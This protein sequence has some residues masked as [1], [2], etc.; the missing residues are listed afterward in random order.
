M[1]RRA[2]LVVLSRRGRSSIAAADWDELERRATVRVVQRNAAPSHD[3]AVELLSGADLLGSTNPCLPRFDAALLDALPDLRAIV[4]YATG[5]DH[6]D[7]PLLARRNVGLSVLPDYATVAVAEH[8]LALLLALATRL[9]LAH[10]RCRGAAA[11]GASL[12][13]IELSDRTIGVIGHGRIGSRVARMCAAL[14]STIV[15]CDVEPEAVAAATAT[16]FA[17]ADLAR[18]LERS[19]AVVV[20]AS[21]EHG[22]PPII[23]KRELDVLRPGSL[24]VNVSRSALVDTDAT[25]AAIRAGRV[26]GYAVDDIVVDPHSD[27][28]L[29][30]EGR[31]LQT[32]HSAWWRDEVLQRGARMWSENLLAAVNGDLR[33]DVTRTGAVGGPPVRP[34]SCP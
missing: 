12:R 27:G 34:R 30:E 16:G 2:T 22:A 4:L 28:D 24:L 32:G 8:A 18:V 23:G 5:H 21:H 20:C 29:L 6:I 19:D 26:R 9:H 15:V 14:G 13:G 33:S 3:E 17:T 7:S 31:V 10:D 25:L 1:Q 11:P